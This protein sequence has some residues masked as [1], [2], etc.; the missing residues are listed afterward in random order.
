VSGA[1]YAK[2]LLLVGHVMNQTLPA[3][4]L[5]LKPTSEIYISGQPY[6]PAEAA[7]LANQEHK[8]GNFHSAVD[9]YD[10]IIARFPD[11]AEALYNRGIIQNQMNS[12]ADALAS[13]DEAIKLKPELAAAHNNR[14][15]ALQELKRYAEA[16]A[17]FDRALALKP[18]VAEPWNNR[19]ATLYEMMRFDDA[20]ASYD[21]AI[22][23]NSDY[24]DAHANRGA[25]LEQLKLYAAALASY[26]QALA[27]KPEDTSILQKRGNLMV[28]Q[29]NMQ[30]AE[31]MFLQALALKPEAPDPWCGLAGIHKFKHINNPVV[32]RIQALLK[33]P[34]I[35][36][37]TQDCLY[38]TLGKVYDDCDRYE[39]AF[40]CYQKA[41]EIRNATV[42]YDPHKV[43]STAD[44]FM[45]VFSR[46]FFAQPCA[47][48]SESL[49]PLFIVGMP[50][51]GTTLMANM[52]SNHPSIATAGELTTITDMTASLEEATGGG[53]SYPQAVMQVTTT[54][55]SSLINAYEER[56]RRDFGR[57]V[58][59]IIDKHPL[60]FWHLGFITHLF[61][62]AR[63]IHCTRHP[64]ATGLSNYFQRFHPVYD[65]SFDLR[66]IGHFYGQYA[67]IMDHWRKV[68]P[69]KMIE[70]SY[71]ELVLNTEAS[72]RQALAILGLAWDDRC[73]TPHTNPCVV[74]TASKWQVRQPI[75]SESLQRWRHY[76]KHLGPL[77]EMLLLS[78]YI[79]D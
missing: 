79:L 29:G 77:K 59:H 53:I 31:R 7:T 66:N 34:G 13:F 27:L 56:L 10:L 67:R 65:Y 15:V 30:E 58:P 70:I 5:Q 8:R 55:A 75:H 37:S 60:N 42:A 11:S 52:L 43:R 72:A 49:S 9:I 40:V 41:N 25:A 21:Q 26:E 61:P 54:R 6:L 78:G 62:R 22:R 64:L 14:G 23:L 18:T 12:P 33:E 32:K 16:L 3:K 38:F 39:E 46:D 24:A 48:A 44:N 17:S 73:L 45:E 36:P 51:S 28:C 20:L 50:R 74:E 4:H 69:T 76:E 35:P 19:G 47:F 68:L 71:E 57:E 63:I 1:G 2:K